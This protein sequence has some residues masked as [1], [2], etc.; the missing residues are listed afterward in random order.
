[1]LLGYARGKVGSMVFSR[2]NGQ[3]IVKAYNSRPR[4]S[5]TD[6]QVMQRAAFLASNKLYTRGV[7]NLFKFAFE[8]KGPNESDFNAFMRNNIKRGVLMSQAAFEE[9]SYPAIGEWLMTKGSLPTISMLALGELQTWILAVNESEESTV[10]ALSKT[11]QEKTGCQK[12]DIVTLCIIKANGSTDLNTPDVNPETRGLVEWVVKQMRIDFGSNEDISNYFGG[13]LQSVP[14]TAGQYYPETWEINANPEDVTLDGDIIGMCMIL[15]RPTK[16]GLKVSTSSLYLSQGAKNAIATGRTETYIYDVLG[17]WGSTP[18][19]VL[20]GG[21]VDDEYTPIVFN[22]FRG[23]GATPSAAKSA[24]QTDKGA[25][26]SV[27]GKQL[28]NYVYIDGDGL[29]NFNRQLLKCNS[30]QITSMRYLPEEQCISFYVDAAKL[31]SAATFTYQD[32][33]LFIVKPTPSV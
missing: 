28:T 23:I 25:Q 14:Q 2:S 11:I 3:Q 24:T 4:E 18:P 31:A 5:K 15:S 29:Q 22:G 9:Q 30:G 17:S 16:R 1:M 21:I 7:Q 10:A 8:D 26:L 20:Q 6:A 13:Y 27:A 19:A 32:E 12:G 33:V